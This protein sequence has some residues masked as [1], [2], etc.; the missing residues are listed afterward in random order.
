MLPAR[1]W[2]GQEGSRRRRRWVAGEETLLLGQTI[3][4]TVR[5][6]VDEYGSGEFQDGYS[7]GTNNLNLGY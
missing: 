6:V 7:E 3:G 4:R 5:L 2:E 1:G